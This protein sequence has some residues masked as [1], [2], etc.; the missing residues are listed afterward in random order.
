MN[1]LKI[2]KRFNFTQYFEVHNRF[3]QTSCCRNGLIK[4]KAGRSSSSTNKA[5]TLPLCTKC[6][7]LWRREL[8]IAQDL[9]GWP[10]NTC[11]YIVQGII[12]TWWKPKLCKL[13]PSHHNYCWRGRQIGKVCGFLHHRV[14]HAKWMGIL[15]TTHSSPFFSSFL[16]FWCCF[17]VA[18]AGF[19]SLALNWH[20]LVG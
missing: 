8:L 12:Q 14:M 4:L 17:A 5:R 16:S 3:G 6:L 10:L 7:S 1:I 19:K 9:Q 2:P 13:W 11:T 20:I 15:C 18:R